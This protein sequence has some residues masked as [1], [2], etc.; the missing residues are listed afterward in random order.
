MQE[1]LKIHHCM[2]LAMSRRPIRLEI[3]HFHHHL[4][5]NYNVGSDDSAG[6]MNT[7]HGAT[8]QK[9]NSRYGLGEIKVLTPID[10]QP[11]IPRTHHY[12]PCRNLS[13]NCF[14]PNSQTLSNPCSERSIFFTLETSCIGGFETRE[15]IVDGSVSRIIPSS[16]ISSIA[17][18]TIS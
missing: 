12:N 16:T 14:F 9:F 2:S 5:H 6:T 7:G 3:V 18:D 4:I 1:N 11:S 10:H 13:A 15:A 8:I 17:R